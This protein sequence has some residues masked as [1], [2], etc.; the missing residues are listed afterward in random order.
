MARYMVFYTGPATAPENMT[1]DAV[2]TEMG[3][4]GKWMEDIGSAL[5]D[6]GAPTGQSAVVTDDGSDGEPLQITGYSII[7]ADDIDTVKGLMAAHPFI[8]EANGDLSISVH[9][10]LSVPEM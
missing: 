2:K 10:L 6:M 9:E 3:L 8:R 4:W 7:E 5:V 1:E